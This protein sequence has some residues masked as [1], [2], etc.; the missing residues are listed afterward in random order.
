[1][2]IFFKVKI[3]YLGR[4]CYRRDSGARRAIN[5]DGKICRRPERGVYGGIYNRIYSCDC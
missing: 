3:G 1:M 2:E 4:G 5:D